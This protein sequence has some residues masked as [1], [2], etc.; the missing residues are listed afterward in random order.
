[1][2]KPTRSKAQEQLVADAGHL[3][4]HVVAAWVGKLTGGR[5]E[6]KPVSP[7]IVNSPVKGG[8][9]QCQVAK[10]FWSRARRG[11][12]QTLPHAIAAVAGDAAD[13]FMKWR[14]SRKPGRD[15]IEEVPVRVVMAL[16][17]RA[18]DPDV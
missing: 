15:R 18:V 2:A 10:D 3:A 12:L 5:F 4:G 16:F 8:G 6:G 1:M 17:P 11:G 9:V 14:R 13:F 7:A